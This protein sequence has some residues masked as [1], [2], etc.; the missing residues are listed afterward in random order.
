MPNL[1]CVCFRQVQNDNF[2]NC[3]FLKSHQTVNDEK[4]KILENEKW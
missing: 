3:V 2:F 1:A 4:S